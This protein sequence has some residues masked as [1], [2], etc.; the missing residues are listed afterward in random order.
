MQ[1]AIKRVQRNV[2]F[3]TLTCCVTELVQRMKCD[4]G[5]ELLANIFQ[6]VQLVLLRVRALIPFSPL[7]LHSVIFCS[8]VLTFYWNHFRQ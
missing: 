1:K 5:T 4:K 2:T 8:F 3:G 6:L 7:H